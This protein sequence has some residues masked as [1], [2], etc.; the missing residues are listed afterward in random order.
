MRSLLASKKAQSVDW[1]FFMSDALSTRGLPLRK[2]IY[3]VVHLRPETGLP[4]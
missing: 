3:F 1:A 2:D 4:A